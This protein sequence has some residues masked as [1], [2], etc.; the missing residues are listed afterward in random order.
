MRTTRER[1]LNS[2]DP[3]LINPAIS[4]DEQ[5]NL[6]PYDPKW[7]FPRNR[8]I[9]GNKAAQRWAYG[10]AYKYADTK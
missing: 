10:W 5:I 2:G 7:E 9:L 3:G 8:I 6:L 4:L 1:L